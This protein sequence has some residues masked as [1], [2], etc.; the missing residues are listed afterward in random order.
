LLVLDNDFAIAGVIGRIAEQSGFEARVAH[1]AEPFFE[2]VL[3]WSPTHLVIDLVMPNTDGIEI[4]RSLAKLACTAGVIITSGA[5]AKILEA[6]RLY[7]REHGLRI[8]GVLPKPFG[9]R[10][11]SD[12][13]L[14]PLPV[15]T[16]AVPAPASAGSASLGEDDV[17]KALERGQFVLRYQPKVDLATGGTVGFEAL[18]RWLHPEFGE[19]LPESFVPLIESSR[20]IDAF[21]DTVFGLAARW[22]SEV[23]AGTALTVSVN[24][25]ARNLS[26]VR[27]V[28]RLEQLCRKSGVAPESLVL[29]LTETG[30]MESRA[31]AIEILTRLRLKGF[32]VALDD[33]GMGYSSMAQLA[34]LPFSEIKIDKTF[35]LAMSGSADALKIVDSMIHLG[36]RLSLVTVAEGVEDAAT[37][38]W[39]RKMGC[40]LAQGYHFSRPLEPAE[41]KARLLLS[42]AV[43]PPP[44]FA[45]ERAFDVNT[46]EFPP[47]NNVLDLL[48]DAVCL[49]DAAGRFV[50]VSAA[51][52]QVFG[53]KP[54]EMVGMSMLDLIFHED[55][56]KTLQAA[57]EVLAGRRLAHFENRY[58]RKDGSIVHIMWSA[59]WSHAHKL[60]VAVARDISERKR[61]ESMQAA[62]YAISAAAYAAEYLSTLFRKV[63][64]VIGTLLPAGS[65][66]VALHDEKSDE[67]TFP[68]YVDTFGDT[69]LPEKP[70]AG[71][72]SG[73]VV[74]TGRPLLLNAGARLARGDA[75]DIGT[76]AI[77]WLGVPLIGQAGTIGA[78]A[79]QSHGTDVAYSAKD[80]E[81]LRFVATQIA[82]T[83]ERKRAEG[84]LQ[85]AALHD[86]LTGL[87]NR[88]LFHDRLQNAL[89]LA[90][91]NRGRLALL[92]IDLDLFKSVNDTFGHAVGDVLLQEV[93]R[94][95]RTCVRESDTVARL[96]G[97]EFL[98]LLTGMAYPKR[99]VAVAEK[100]RACLAQPF[101]VGESRVTVS[102]SIGIAAYPEHA[103]DHEALVRYAD[104]AMY[105][106][107]RRGGNRV[108]L[109]RT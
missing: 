72:L 100:I 106:A 105:E 80:V 107:K 53:Y 87:P 63:H 15:R 90:R 43:T 104:E 37:A 65:F 68:Y 42:K 39:L 18:A 69:P 62:L 71:S 94:R 49:V 88:A 26:D 98:V 58:V 19:M 25:S 61:G 16:R 1:E 74:R 109:A 82:A 93:G 4:M 70:G 34:T 35:V 108:Q 11:L 73:Q 56:Q 51:A 38:E 20:Y 60:R 9:P 29:E 28:D 13:L 64:S 22:A 84:R 5:G 12:L 48:L 76:A 96:G 67:L 85:H 46:G 78:V 86:P 101:D 79:V 81:L 21:T 2:A 59:R 40:K 17:A 92:F 8:V 30:A 47:L 66:S 103:S 50:F 75:P 55:V 52:E 36:E 7:A 32:Q 24:L 14:K 54:E 33:F 95:L 10:V 41:A 3:A 6:A 44:S 77:E 99:T 89:A 97:D 45:A 27:L 57:G 102:P 91:R 31:D 23:C 83:V